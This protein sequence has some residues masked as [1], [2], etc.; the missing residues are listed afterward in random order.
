MRSLRTRLITKRVGGLVLTMTL[1]LILV[2]A[3]SNNTAT[4]SPLAQ[5]CGAVHTMHSLV[6]P[7][8]WSMVKGAEDCFWQAF[9][10]CRPATLMLAQSDSQTSTIHTFS[11]QDENGTCQIADSVQHFLTPHPPQAPVNYT[12]VSMQQQT[13]GLHVLSCGALGNILIPALRSHT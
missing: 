9:Q 6:V 8:D 7:M 12:C 5:Q 1:F 10:Q 11:F 4:T 2:T 13:D 3:C